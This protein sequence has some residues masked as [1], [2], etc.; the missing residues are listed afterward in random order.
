MYMLGILNPKVLGSIVVGAALVAGAYTIANFG[1]P[2]ATLPASSIQSEAP[3]R[4]AIPVTDKDENGI[5]DWRDGFFTAKPIELRGATSSPYIPPTTLTGQLGISLFQNVV[6]SRN[7]GALGKTDEEIVATTAATLSQ[8]VSDTIYGL[9][10]ILIIEEWTDADIRNY[11]NTMGGILLNS[12]AGEHENEIDIYNDIMTRGQSERMSEL[13][14]IRDD[15]LMFRDESLKVPVP[16]LLVK[17]HLDLINTYNAMYSDVNA[18]TL[19]YKDPVVTLMRLKRYGDD[20]LGLAYALQNMN[21]SLQMHSSLFSQ[22]D[23]AMFFS[24]FNQVNR[25]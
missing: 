6:R 8:E 23:P 18:M 15:Y 10:D 20:S 14:V 21:Q 17:Q 16:R 25:P 7:A 24:Q 3:A 22:N 9:A 4:I 5:E 13:E 12:K 19:G 1:D 2:I 11:A